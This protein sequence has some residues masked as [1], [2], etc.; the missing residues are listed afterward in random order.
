MN[1]VVSTTAAVAVAAAAASGDAADAVGTETPK[2]PLEKKKPRVK[3]AAAVAAALQ[4]S[5]SRED[6]IVS[7][8]KRGSQVPLPDLDDDLECLEEEEEEEENEQEESCDYDSDNLSLF[9]E[10]KKQS[11]H[12]SETTKFARGRKESEGEEEKAGSSKTPPD[13]TGTSYKGSLEHLIPTAE[14]GL[15]RR[16][17]KKN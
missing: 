1:T 17:P 10:K 5:D 11:S 2:H 4:I 3:R 15:K 13:Q 6:S 8:K 7:K 9:S 16:G 12:T 14:Q